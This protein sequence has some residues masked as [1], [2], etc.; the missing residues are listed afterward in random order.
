MHA[1]QGSLTQLHIRIT[2]EAFESIKAQI[3]SLDI[4]V[5]WVC[6]R[7]RVS[8]SSRNLALYLVKGLGHGLLVE[9]GGRN[10]CHSLS[11]QSVNKDAESKTMVQF[12]LR[13][14]LFIK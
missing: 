8:V 2:W 13:T 7:D 1:F 10:C 12:T 3:S 4:Q 6:G 14:N 11:G 5:H 9:T